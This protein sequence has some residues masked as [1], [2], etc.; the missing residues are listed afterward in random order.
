MARVILLHDLVAL[1]KFG[2]LLA[3]V[4]D[5]FGLGQKILLKQISKM[6]LALMLLQQNK[7]NKYT[8]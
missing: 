1:E 2:S 4:A 5:V 3:S 8:R 7:I 6:N